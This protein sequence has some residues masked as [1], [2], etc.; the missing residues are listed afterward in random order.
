MI[1]IDLNKMSQASREAYLVD[2][3][4]DLVMLVQE[5][6]IVQYDYQRDI[7]SYAEKAIADFNNR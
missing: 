7:V 1:Q 5:A 6:K 4:A 3:V 2:L